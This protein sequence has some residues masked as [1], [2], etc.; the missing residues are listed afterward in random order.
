[1]FSFG[2]MKDWEVQVFDADQN[3]IN[4]SVE[5]ISRAL[6]QLVLTSVQKVI[7]GLRTVTVLRSDMSTKAIDQRRKVRSFLHI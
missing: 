5:A 2:L 4:G 7:C 3:K 6:H 1:M